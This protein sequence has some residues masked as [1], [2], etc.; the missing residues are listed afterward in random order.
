M[1]SCRVKLSST[2]VERHG[3]NTRRKTKR[4]IRFFLSACLPALSLK[5]FHKETCEKSVSLLKYEQMCNKLTRL[6]SSLS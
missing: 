2:Y 1:L 6:E 3:E 4:Y 5:I